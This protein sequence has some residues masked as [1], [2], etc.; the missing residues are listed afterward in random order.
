MKID[1]VVSQTLRCFVAF[2]TAAFKRFTYPNLGPVTILGMI[3]DPV[4]ILVS[5]FA[6]WDRTGEGL[7]I[8]SVHAHRAENGL[9][10]DGT[11]CG[12]RLITV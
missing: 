9:R 12:P 2:P 7:F 10:A 3:F 1:G 6:A 8:S 4:N 5:L 11:L